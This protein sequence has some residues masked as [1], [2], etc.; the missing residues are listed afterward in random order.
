VIAQ[1][2]MA[3]VFVAIAVRAARETGTTLR[4]GIRGVARSAAS[5]GW[6]LV[7]TASLRAA[8]LAT[9]AVGAGLGVT[10]LATLQIALT[11]FSTVAFVLDALAIAGQALVGHGL[12]AD[13]VP[14]VRAVARRLVQWGVGLGVILGLLLAALSP[15]LGPVFTGDAGIHR[16]LTA[17]TLVLAVGLPVAGYV[18]VLDG[19]LIGAGD[20]RYLALAG[21]VNLAIYAPALILVAWLTETGRVAGTPA[22]LALWA[23]FGLVY[24]GARALTLGLRARG[25]RWIVTGVARA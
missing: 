13:D 25:D 16:M 17:V 3:A 22:L 12:G 5:G 23:G 11:L 6:L 20:A 24:I 1:W 7:R 4:P 15:V 9:V 14:R 10:G 19:V 21:L 8:I 2:G 18:F